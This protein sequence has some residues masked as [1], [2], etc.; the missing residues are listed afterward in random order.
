MFIIISLVIIAGI[1]FWR[2]SI[3]TTGNWAYVGFILILGG[4]VGNLIDRITRGSVVD[5]LDFLV[6]PVFNIAD[7]SICI[8]TAALMLSY[9]KEKKSH[10]SDSV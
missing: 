9:Y 7:M 5:F 6:W 2:N 1:I 4:A 3:L 10:A 8:G